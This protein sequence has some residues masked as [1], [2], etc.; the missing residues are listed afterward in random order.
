M[1]GVIEDAVAKKC[2]R[3]LDAAM[4]DHVRPAKAPIPP[5]TITQLKRN[6]E[7]LLPKTMRFKTAYFSTR[8][9]KSYKAADEIGL[10]TMME[11]ESFFEFAQAVTGFQLHRDN[12]V[13]CILYEPGDYA[14]PHTDHHPE[15]ENAKTG[16]VDIHL[17]FSNNA[18]S[19]Q[20]LVCEQ[21]GYLS[22]AYDITSSGTIAAY[23]LP[24]WHYTTPLLGKARNGQNA[25]RWLLLG[26]Y[27]IDA[28]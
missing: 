7:E 23:K 10:F 13:Q 11:S 20:Y 17:M 14:G 19:S 28:S 26:T 15:N 2:Q 21:G 3:L 4:L 16:Y 6:Y 9:S 1:T 18:V 27:D 22:N 12:A 8:S 5:E 25:R 24:F